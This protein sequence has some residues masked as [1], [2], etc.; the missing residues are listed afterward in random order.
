MIS[1]ITQPSAILIVDYCTKKFCYNF[2]RTLFLFFVVR[3][4]VIFNNR[5]FTWEWQ[6]ANICHHET[7]K[8]PEKSFNLSEWQVIYSYHFLYEFNLKFF[9]QNFATGRKY[10]R[11]F[12]FLRK[13]QGYKV[14]M[15]LFY[16]FNN[17][18]LKFIFS[19]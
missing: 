7:L 8:T 17:N 15:F 11:S 12:L 10:G 14:I 2:F 13:F 5:F 16:F 19:F 4:S 3:E 9:H 6:N 18:C 1:I